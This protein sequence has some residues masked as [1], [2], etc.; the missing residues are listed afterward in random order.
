MTKMT[1]GPQ[2][3]P[4]PWGQVGTREQKHTAKGLQE[5][6]GAASPS[7]GDPRGGSHTRAGTTHQPHPTPA[8][9]HSEHGLRLLPY[10]VQVHVGS[11]G[12]QV[13]R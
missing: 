13:G 7:L 12:E 5:V 4:R 11:C 10:A 9:P 6:G 3:P 8:S 1:L 2:W